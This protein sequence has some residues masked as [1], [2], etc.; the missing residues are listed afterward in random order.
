[1]S[2]GQSVSSEEWHPAT[3]TLTP[4]LVPPVRPLL[5]SL[6]TELPS[7][8]CAHLLTARELGPRLAWANLSVEAEALFRSF[9][10]RDPRIPA[11]GRG[12]GSLSPLLL[13]GCTGSLG[14]RREGGGSAEERR[15]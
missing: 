5:L 10:G 15:I 1:M 11:S 8:L 2:I 7:S 4:H 6:R 3:P 9:P 13:P 12:G 14:T